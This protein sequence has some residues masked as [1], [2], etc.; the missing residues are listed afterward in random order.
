MELSKLNEKLASHINEDEVYE[1]S[2]M[3]AFET[4]RGM[5]ETAMANIKLSSKPINFNRLANAMTQLKLA[6]DAYELANDPEYTGRPRNEVLISC[7]GFVQEAK[8]CIG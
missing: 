5:I 3:E 1:E 2:L 8:K 4:V 7:Y 6:A